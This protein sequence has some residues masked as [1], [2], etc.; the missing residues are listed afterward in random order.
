MKMYYLNSTNSANN[1]L[2]VN[3][4]MASKK[5]AFSAVNKNTNLKSDYNH[6]YKE[7]I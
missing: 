4:L 1:F 6:K 2:A 3:L 7:V 5:A